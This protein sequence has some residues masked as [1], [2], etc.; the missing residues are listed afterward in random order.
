MQTNRLVKITALCK[1]KQGKTL[2]NFS[3]SCGLDMPNISWGV[4]TDGDLT[5]IFYKE[6]L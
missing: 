2:Y 3:S 6:G 1:K 4:I 5:N